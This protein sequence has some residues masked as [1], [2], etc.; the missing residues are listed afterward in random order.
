MGQAADADAG[1]YVRII[2]MVKWSE[3][4]RAMAAIMSG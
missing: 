3:V 1:K 2:G 4:L